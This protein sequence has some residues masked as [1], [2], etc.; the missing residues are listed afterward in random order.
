MAGPAT[1]P[2]AHKPAE[3]SEP[4]DIPQFPRPDEDD[5]KAP[6]V[7]EGKNDVT[8]VTKENEDPKHDPFVTDKVEEEDRSG[9]NLVTNSHGEL[10][11]AESV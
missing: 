7:K 3:K 8:L 5:F 2:G 4:A 10:V 9:W 11:R 1:K 6:V